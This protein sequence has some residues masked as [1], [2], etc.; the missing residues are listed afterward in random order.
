MGAKIKGEKC[1]N[2]KLKL[3]DQLFYV[4][5]LP[6]V[7]VNLESAPSQMGKQNGLIWDRR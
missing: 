2:D 1:Y 5:Q 6:S 4:N 3:E 7:L